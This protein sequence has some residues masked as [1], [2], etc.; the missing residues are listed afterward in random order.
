MIP[1][2]FR[3]RAD[4]FQPGSKLPTFLRIRCAMQK[5]ENSDYTINKLQSI[6]KIPF[7][8]LLLADE[9]R[10]AIEKYIYHSDVYVVNNT[11]QLKPIA[12]FALYKTSDAEIEIKNIAVSEDLQSKGIG[13]FLINEIKRIATE[14]NYRNIIV[15]TTDC[16]YRQISFYERNGFSKY[17]IKKDFF[18]ENYPEPIIENGIMVRDMVML[19]IKL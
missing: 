6:D 18:I 17:D 16:G 4:K 7:D 12:V 3:V 14:D 15:G 19:K 9:T 1:Q 13:G 8:L 2:R 11:A 5:N 10:Y